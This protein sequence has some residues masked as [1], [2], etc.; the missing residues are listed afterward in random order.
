MIHTT[1]A[2]TRTDSNGKVANGAIKKTM[3]NG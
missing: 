2:P 3:Y 1:I